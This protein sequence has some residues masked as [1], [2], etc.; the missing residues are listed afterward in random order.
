MSKK[1]K[2]RELTKELPPY[3]QKDK[4]SGNY[5]LFYPIAKSIERLKEDVNTVDKNNNLQTAN[6][7]ESVERIADMVG[8][9]QREGETLEQ[10]RLRVLTE[11]Q[12]L[13]NEGSIE[14]VFSVLL[15]LIDADLD[16]LRYQDWRQL[17][18]TLSTVA[19]LFPSYRVESS[20]VSG[21]EI[22]EILN[23]LSPATKKVEAQYSGTFTPV[24]VDDYLSQSYNSANGFGFL[25]E[26]NNPSDSGGTFGGIIK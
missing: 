2:T 17:Y 25:N 9:S 13:T 10:F 14:D 23:R 8:L 1:D 24:S 5:S 21:S 19:F 11:F 22:L 20:P 26:Y 3:L 4:G 12:S 18:N 7:T 15:T 6:K 16:E